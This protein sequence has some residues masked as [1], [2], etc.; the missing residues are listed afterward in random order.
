M[1]Y[2]CAGKNVKIEHSAEPRGDLV[3]CPCCG[4][5]RLAQDALSFFLEKPG[6]PAPA[7]F[8]SRQKMAMR[9]YVFNENILERIPLISAADIVLITGARPEMARVSA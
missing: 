3:D 1:C 6:A 7:A 9:I 8:S 4:K 5:Y 2:W